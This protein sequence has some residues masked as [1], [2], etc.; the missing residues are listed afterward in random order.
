MVIQHTC[1][2]FFRLTITLEPTGDGTTLHW[3]QTFADTRIAEAVAHIV[4][5]ANEENLDRLG[6]EVGTAE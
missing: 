3:D 2:P 5:P 1:A 4:K 6:A